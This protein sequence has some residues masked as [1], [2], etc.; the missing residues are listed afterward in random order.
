MLE[1]VKSKAGR[2]VVEDANG[3]A[4]VDLEIATKLGPGQPTANR[5]QKREIV[6][7]NPSPDPT[8][9]SSMRVTPNDTSLH[10]GRTSRAW[11]H[12]LLEGNRIAA[13]FQYGRFDGQKPRANRHAFR[14]WKI[15]R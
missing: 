15:L 4:G 6:G 8:S 1:P 12:R 2:L 7:S 13:R 3:I 5:H 14:D 11:S 9:A 10:S